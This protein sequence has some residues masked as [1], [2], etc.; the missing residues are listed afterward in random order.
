MK[1]LAIIGGGSAGLAAAKWAQWGLKGHQ[2]TLFEKSPRLGGIWTSGNNHSHVWHGMRTNLSQYSC[3]FSDFPHE[4]NTSLFPTKQE[5]NRYL[6]LYIN[7]FN[8][9]QHIQENTTVIHMDRINETWQITYEKNNKLHHDNFDHV[10]LANGMF[11]IPHMPQFNASEKFR[12]KIIHSAEYKQNTDFLNKDVVI[13]GGGFSAVEIASNISKTARSVFHV[14]RTSSWIIPKLIS[15]KNGTPQPLDLLLYKREFIEQGIEPLTVKEKNRKTNRF[16]SKLTGQNDM[17]DLYIDPNSEEEQRIVISNDYLRLLKEKKI[18]HHRS[19]ITGF[20][21]NDIILKNN[22]RINAQ[23]VICCTGY[24]PDLNFLAPTLLSALQYDPQDSL[25]PAMLYESVLHPQLP[26]LFFIG[27]G[28]F[29]GAYF[30][31]MELQARLAV[32][33]FSRRASYPNEK[34]IQA[35]FTKASEIRANHQK[36]QFINS[37]YSTLTDFYAKW[38]NLLPPS[39]DVNTW[40]KLNGTPVIPSDYLRYGPGAN[41]AVAEREKSRVSDFMRKVNNHSF[42]STKAT[43]GSEITENIQ[44]KPAT[45]RN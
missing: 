15:D 28:A 44:R 25:Q 40:N 45:M 19:E 30:P 42:F 32:E 27:M 9:Q 34:E 1:K 20:E 33:L 3:V 5:M 36:P 16:L 10:I 26:H 8:L 18:I 37:N 14:N 21:D 2:I 13:V 35:Y 7:S 43:K 29:R 39:T 12:G 24:S 6:S 38:A 17:P 41:I 4:Q 11:S 23:I 22:S 31:I